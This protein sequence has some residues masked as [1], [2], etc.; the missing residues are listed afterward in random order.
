MASKNKG[1]LLA[2]VLVAGVAVAGSYFVF[3]QYAN[4]E[5]IIDQGWDEGVSTLGGIIAFTEGAVEYK[6]SE[7]AWI[8]AA[9]GT[10]LAEGDSVEVLGEGKA[11]IN[12]DDGSVLR[13]S[14]DSGITLTTMDPNHMVVA[15]NGGKVYSRVIKSDRVFE[16][17]AGG[18]TYESLGT[19]YM[20]CNKDGEKGVEVYESKVKVKELGTET[21]VDEGKYYYVEHNGEI[22]VKSVTDFAAT[23]LEDDFVQ[24]NKSEDQEH[25][26]YELGVFAADEDSVAETMDEPITVES[27]V[28]G[29]QLS[30]LRNGNVSW[31]TTGE[32]AEGYK[33]VWSKEQNPTYPL[34]S[35]DQYKYYSDPATR[36]GAVH[37]FDGGGTYYIRVCEYLGG[38][39]GLYSNQVSATFFG[40]DDEKEIVTETKPEKETNS[41]VSSI[42][43]SASGAS[44]NWS[45]V[46]YSTSGYKIVWSKNASPTYPTRSGDKYIYLSS[47]TASSTSLSAFDGAGT[48]Y[49][50]VC[51]YLGGKCGVYSNQIQVEL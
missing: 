28:T 32:S 16:I 47:P 37:A 39:C 25:F 31:T 41:G 7:G 6:T 38:E 43:A 17:V 11:I 30:Y 36:N 27:T 45:T 18:V 5:V 34:R 50:R 26:K 21:T 14:S 4:E 10:D 22:A 19:A 44:V 20:T 9:E 2:L 1:G 3:T 13:L 48:Y 33:L 8:R 24:W 40:D 23:I 46:G 35:G 49:V 51:E 42:S 29:I 15:N 12:L